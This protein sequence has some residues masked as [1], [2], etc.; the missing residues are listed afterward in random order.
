VYATSQSLP[1]WTHV[2]A[3]LQRR[4]AVRHAR[5]AD[6]RIRNQSTYLQIGATRLRDRRYVRSSP[7][8]LVCLQVQARYGGSS[9]RFGKSNCGLREVR[10]YLRPV[11]CR[12][13]IMARLRFNRS[14]R[15]TKRAD[16]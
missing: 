6:V 2:K 3:N 7:D 4:L 9:E 8:Q 16:A 1:Q 10:N 14:A 5:D 15:Q 12:G 13:L 11:S